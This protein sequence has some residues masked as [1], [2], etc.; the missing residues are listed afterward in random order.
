MGGK[1]DLQE[2]KVDLH[3]QL[4]RMYLRNIYCWAN[5]RLQLLAEELCNLIRVRT[6]IIVLAKERGP[7][8]CR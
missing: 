5:I 3:I 2:C 1:V 4:H 6:K 7:L 8:T